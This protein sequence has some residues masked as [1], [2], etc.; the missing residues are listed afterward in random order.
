MVDWDAGNVGLWM[1]KLVPKQSIAPELLDG[2]IGNH[3]LLRANLR[4]M[5]WANRWLGGH[6]AV[7]RR[8]AR[9]V[10]VMPPEHT[11][12]ILDVATGG[13]DLPLTLHH[14][15]RRQDRAIALLASDVSGEVLA[16]AQQELEGRPVRL[17]RHDALH[18]PFADCSVDIV[19]CSQSLHHFLYDEAL[20]LLQEL[21][22][23]A[24]V[25]VI[26][27]DL[28]RSYPAYWGARLLAAG[29]VSALSRHDGPLSVL[30]AY[31]PAEVAELV[32]DAALPARVR[33]ARGFRLEIEL[34]KG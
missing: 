1:L 26:V 2:A 7:L 13:G 11:V 12:T 27:N 30:R 10:A 14:W 6:R 20:R 24:R 15:G 32:K 16:V 22:R 19:T 8:V 29:P 23:V 4:D 21:A 5:A 31:T 9:W 25:G 28:R 18:M 34:T 33:R 3:Q 17:L